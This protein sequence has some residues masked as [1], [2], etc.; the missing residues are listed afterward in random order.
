M[1]QETKPADRWVKAEVTA[2]EEGDDG[3]KIFTVHAKGVGKVSMQDKNSVLTVSITKIITASGASSAN[4]ILEEGLRQLQCVQASKITY[5]KLSAG[6]GKSNIDQLA[7]NGVP[8]EVD[9]F[10]SHSWHD[11]KETKFKKWE[12]HFGKRRQVE[13]CD[14]KVWLDQTIINQGNN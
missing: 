12:E 14:A 8:G 11:D 5:E 6:S 1:L 2:I 13:R 7:E 10:V 9:Y 3:S 4:E